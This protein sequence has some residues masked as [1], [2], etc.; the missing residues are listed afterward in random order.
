MKKAGVAVVGYGNIGRCAMESLE[1]APDMECVGVVRRS[2]SAEGISGLSAYRVVTDIGELEG[3]DVAL[4]CVPSRMVRGTALKCLSRGINTVDCFDIHADVVALRAELAAVAKASGA[5][6]VMAAGG[7]PGSDS[8][9]RTLFKALAP[10]GVTYTNFGPGR[11]MGHT[12]AAR[13]VKGVKDALSITMPLGNGV[14]GRL[15]NVELEDGAVFAEVEEAIKSDPYFA[16]DRTEVREVE[17]VAALN[18]LE[19]GV[20]M[21]RDGISGCTAGQKFQFDMKINNPA[22][23]AQVMVAAARASLLREPGCYTLIEIPPLDLLPG[24]REALIGE[25][26]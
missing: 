13:A 9:V 18:T 23:T 20:N 3:V 11:S 4:L 16:S 21:V 5:V 22:L 14:H 12:V 17:C 2:G 26:V 6:G 1:H 15:V 7:D 24:N 10:G 8:V 19:H 25:L